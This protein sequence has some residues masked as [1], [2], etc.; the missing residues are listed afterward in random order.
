MPIVSWPTCCSPGSLPLSLRALASPAMQP[1]QV[2]LSG[3]S[4]SFLFPLSHPRPFPCSP[5][6]SLSHRISEQEG[7]LVQGEARFLLILKP[8]SPC[9]SLSHTTSSDADGWVR[10]GNEE[11]L[12][13]YPKEPSA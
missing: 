4:A 9:L 8:G 13:S 6:L 5:S 11:G 7:S 12:G 1:T 3:C 10:H 2:R